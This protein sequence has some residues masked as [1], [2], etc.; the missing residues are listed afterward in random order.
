MKKSKQWLSAAFVA[1]SI[2]SSATA[3]LM[4]YQWD[5]VT[6]NNSVIQNETVQV[7]FTID[8]ATTKTSTSIISLN[9][10]DATKH[11]YEE[12][13]VSGYYKVGET[14]FRFVT[15]GDIFVGSDPLFGDIFVPANNTV[16]IIENFAGS[17]GRNTRFSISGTT[18]YVARDGITPGVIIIHFDDYDTPK[19]TVVGDGLDQP[20]DTLKLVSQGG[21]DS[22]VF[23]MGATFGVVSSV[24]SGEGSLALVPEPGSLALLGIGGLLLVRRRR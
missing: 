6:A 10:E 1:V 19:D 23:L 7:V 2:G 12:A 14:L 3:E 18:D 4:T 15:S 21:V 9:G 16:T 8:T 24:T 20:L 13:L 17:R 5:G 11:V 22:T